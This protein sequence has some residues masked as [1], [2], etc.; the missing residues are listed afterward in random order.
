MELG[1]EGVLSLG[2]NS[3]YVSY[4]FS[5]RVLLQIPLI[6]VQGMW[7]VD[8]EEFGNAVKSNSLRLSL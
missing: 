4:D 5:S 8:F 7:Q 1:P 3:P 2:E 6:R